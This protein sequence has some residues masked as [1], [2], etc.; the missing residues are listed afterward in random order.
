MHLW[1][2]CSESPISRILQNRCTCLGCVPPSISQELSGAGTEQIRQCSSQRDYYCKRAILC[3]SSSKI[4]TPHPLFRPVSVSPPPPPTKV[5]SRRAERGVGGQ[6]FGRTETQD[7]PLTVLI[8]LRCS[9]SDTHAPCTDTP[10]PDYCSDS[11]WAGGKLART[12]LTEG[13]KTYKV[14]S[15]YRMPYNISCTVHS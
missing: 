12:S 4:L 15:R 14:H 11:G 7:C 9:Q 2:L 1:D 8:S 6:Y 10:M 3:L 13:I 5:H